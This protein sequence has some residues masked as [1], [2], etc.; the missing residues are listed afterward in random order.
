MVLKQAQNI[1]V[2]KSL[3]YED[4]RKCLPVARLAQRRSRKIASLLLSLARL[5][6]IGQRLGPVRRDALHA[7]HQVPPIRVR[8]QVGPL[9]EP[10]TRI[11]Q[12]AQSHCHFLDRI[13]IKYSIIYV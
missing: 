2:N 13:M 9:Q 11:S 7:Q 8:N 3:E 12:V 1:K 5:C 10:P 6:R 4:K